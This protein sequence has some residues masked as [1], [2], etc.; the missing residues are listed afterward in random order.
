M[1]D[2]HVKRVEPVAVGTDVQVRVFTL[3]DGDPHSMAPSQRDPISP[4]AI[5]CFDIL[6]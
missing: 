3:S 5:P 1:P 4:V 6:S 2:Y